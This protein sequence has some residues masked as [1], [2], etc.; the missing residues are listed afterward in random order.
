VADL[1]LILG[2]KNYSSWSL[3]PYLALAHTGAPFDEVVI[4]LNRP[5]TREKILAWSPAGRVPILRHQELAVWDSLAICEYV[6]ELFPAAGLWP[7]DRAARAVARSVSAEMHSGFAALRG[8]LPMNV[9]AEKRKTVPAEAA[10]DIERIRAI[11]R[12]CRERFGEGGPFLFGAFSIADAM[13]APVVT[14]LRTY[15]V[16]IDGVEVAYAQA[17]WDLP[18]LQRWVED[19]RK[20]PW[21]IEGYE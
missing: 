14:R 15:G 16:T 10:A 19:A 21:V 2:N 12:D 18:S 17:I 6:A 4:P 13:F 8:S 3:R 1:K 5:D 9:R 7:A 11:W 20:E